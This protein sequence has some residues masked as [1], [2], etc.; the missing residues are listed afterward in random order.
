MKKIIA[1]IIMIIFCSPV[2]AEDVSISGEE[3]YNKTVN[4]IAKGEMDLNPINII[5]NLINSVFEE[6]SETKTL[7][8]SILLI[9]I[10]A[11]LLRIL[12]EA[13][14]EGEANSAASFACFVLMAG[15][16][17]KIF[18]EVIGY[19][20]EV[21]HSLCGFITKFEP[22]FVGLL[23]SGGAITQAAAFQPVLAGSVYVLGL[24]VDK[25]ILP[26]NY[27]SAIL[28]I[29]NNIGDRVELGTLNR[30]L[31][32]ASKWLLT[33]VLTLFSSILAIYGFGTSAMN[34][35]TLKG[36]KFAVG[37]F[38]PVVGGIL[39]DTI[40]TVLS[41]ANLLKNAVGTAGMITIITIASMPIIKIWIMMMLLKVTAAV[42]E[43]FSDKRITSMLIVV[44]EAVANI[45]S[46]VITSVM[47]FVISIGIILIS[48]GVNL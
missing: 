28:G 6:I 11:G 30:L 1:L 48:T 12:S 25:C 20:T 40:D 38:V 44:S 9:A 8:K 42:I 36:I 31:Q 13:F 18:A 39:S 27:F 45:F 35:V 17:V 23:A 34:T 15:T 21:I 26:M 29:V 10:A 24:L 7:I 47:L 33:G 4:E 16:T 14:G 37:S 46:M 41:G 19:G 5:N 32:S 43:P 3:F 22:V 2:Y